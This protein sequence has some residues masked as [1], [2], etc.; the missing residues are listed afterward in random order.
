MTNRMPGEYEPHERTLMCWPARDSI[1]GSHLAQA[2]EDYATIARAIARFE[3]I[4]MIARPDRADSAVE[5]CGPDVEVIEL[6]IDDSWA[7]DSGPMVVLDDD[8]GRVALDWTFTAWGHKFHPYADDAQL[9]RRWSATVGLP[10]RSLDMVLEGGA[11]TVDGQGTLITTEQCLL[12]PNRNP[13]MTRTDIETQLR[14]ELGV[15]EVVWLPTGLELDDDTDGHVDNIAAYAAPGVVLLQGCDDP[16]RADHD[17]MSV[18]RRCLDG[19]I[20]ATGRPLRVVEVPVL[21]F[22]SVDGRDGPEEVAVPYLNLY[23]CNGGVVVP[24]TGHPADGDMLALIGE[25]FPGR[26]VVPVPGTTL[27]I[28][29]GGPHCITQQVPACN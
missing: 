16:A 28:G 26:Q 21:P 25:Q 8:G 11:I 10:S 22:V 4:T 20:D 13:D 14:D 2:F 19:H 1:W 3:P 7:R 23:I 5:H 6:P 12:H 17:R 27:A 9:A 24:T 15:A 18:N 29:G